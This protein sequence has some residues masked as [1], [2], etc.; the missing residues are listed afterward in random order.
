MTAV[1]TNVTVPL[2]RAYADAKGVALGKG[3][4]D[5][6][7]AVLLFLN[8]N[9]ATLRAMAT[10]LGITEGFGKRGRYAESVYTAVADSILGVKPESP[11]VTGA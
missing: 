4:A 5:T 8:D 10:G 7:A 2:A 11:E 6:R 3:K 1:L 9:P